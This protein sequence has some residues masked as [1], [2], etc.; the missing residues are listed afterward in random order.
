MSWLQN[1][2]AKIF[3][4][5]PAVIEPADIAFGTDP[6]EW[7]PTEYGR[8]LTTSSAVYSCAELRA[9]SLAGLA[10]HAYQDGQEL[11]EGPAVE[12]LRKVNP[13][14]TWSRLMH[15]TELSLCIWG[16]SFWVVER[17]DDGEGV[18]TEIWWA[19]P[20]NMR[21][22]PDE[23]NYIAGYIYEWNNKRI[24]FKKSEVIWHRKP[25]P[26]DEFAGLSPL[27][28]TRLAV[29]TGHAALR[30]NHAIFKNG[31]QIAG[32][33]TPDDKDAT[34]QADQVRALRDMLENRFKGADKAHRLAVLGQ[35]AKFQP[36]GVSPKDAQFLELMQWTRSD[37]AMV[38]GVPPELIGDNTAATYNN[39]REAHR[40]IWNDTLIP[41][42]EMIAAEI[43]EQLMPMFGVEGL[44]VAWDYSGVNA[45]AADMVEIAA[46]AKDW[47][48]IGVPLNAILAELAPQFLT[49]SDAGEGFP[50]GNAPGSIAG[51]QPAAMPGEDAEK[52][53]KFAEYPGLRF[54]APQGVRDAARKGLR[55][56]EEGR[57]GDGLKPQTVA[58]ARTISAGRD[59]SPDKIRRMNAWF[60][61]HASDRK[62]GWNKP[63]A[64]T[65]GHVAWLL[66]GGDAGRTWAG[67]MVADMD[68]IDA[69]RG[70]AAP[71]PTWRMPTDGPIELN[72]AEHA[73]RYRIFEKQVDANEAAML[74]EI[75]RLFTEQNEAIVAKLREVNS[76]SIDD[77]SDVNDVWEEE[78][79]GAFFA[80]A[81][82][83]LITQTASAAALAT[84]SELN[85][86]AGA[87]D[88][89]SPE[90][91]QFLKQR[92]QRFAQ[93][94]NETTWERLKDS[95]N[96]GIARGE[97]IDE[98]ADRVNLV[99]RDRIRSSAETIARTETIGAL[100]GGTLQAAKVSGVA[101][102]K[103]W[104][105][106]MDD[107]TRE[108]HYQAHDEY[109]ANPIPVDED[110]IVGG[111]ALSA[112][113]VAR[114]GGPET[115]AEVINCRCSM[116]FVVDLP[117]F[118]D[119][120]PRTVLVSDIA[121]WLKEHP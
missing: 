27:A 36:L 57:S 70:K 59:V 90:T 26:L 82:L 99:M 22:V 92:A 38:Y 101:K 76:K 86:S 69:E 8:Y 79:W 116:T 21:I 65:P 15:M 20:D 58:E 111:V 2:I 60:A 42:A 96:A 110:F 112:P 80:A 13:H 49:Y 91:Q 18:P 118:D 47:A 103:R 84:L 64:E 71:K 107:R 31:V 7:S 17:G 94:V 19:R 52:S 104:L 68:R 35:A 117:G 55:L 40:G 53:A 50:W 120:P 25:N 105:A 33:V 74:G 54:V 56:H 115:A 51:G 63:G 89:E 85:V 5:G 28:A 108:T 106:G 34:W 66:W 114:G 45:L 87:W 77:E 100:N 46:Q 3:R 30:S 83:P 119:T 1:A 14:W 93:Q 78:F 75:R 121:Q 44:T 95:L 109:Q 6:A 32:L 43:N 72:S 48:S 81:F 12:L 11:T 29:D 16:Q 113:G 4:L 41:E 9:R 62:P 61:R 88:L 67:R 23:Q 39:V 10:I 102:A 97:N 37:V 24:A 73:R 98:L